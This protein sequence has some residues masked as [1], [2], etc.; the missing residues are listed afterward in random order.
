MEILP[1]APSEAACLVPLLQDL[2]ALHV[3]HHPERYTAEPADA[4]LTAWLTDW[5]ASDKIEALVARSPLGVTMGYLI[6]E[7]EERAALPTRAAETRAMLHHIAVDAPFQRIG[8]GKAL[9]S[10]MKARAL[11]QGADVL[12]ATYAPFNAASAALMHSLGLMPVLTYAE[13][14]APSE[15]ALGSVAAG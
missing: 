10:A 13:W 6:W 11:A 15:A 12:G 3:S 1:L 2:H 7:I 8:V 5:L 9:M 14:R 4:D